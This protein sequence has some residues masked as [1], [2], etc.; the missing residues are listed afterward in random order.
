[1]RLLGQARAGF[2]PCPPEVVKLCLAHHLDPPSGPTALLDPC[3]GKGEA[4]AQLAEGLGATAYG[5]ELCAGRSAEAVNLLPHL[6]GPADFLATDV[7]AGS[8]GLAWVNPPY[9]DEIGGGRRVE[10]SFLMRVT[11]LLVKHG[12]LCFLTAEHVLDRWELREYLP[13]QYEDLSAWAFPSEH[14]RFREVVVFGRRRAQAVKEVEPLGGLKRAVL[15]TGAPARLRLP[16]SPGPKTFAK[17]GFTEEELGEALALSPLQKVMTTVRLP[18]PA[19]PPLP[20]AKGHVALMLAAGHLDGVVHPDGEPPHVVR[21]TAT[22][23]KFISEQSEIATENGT[24]TR[25]VVSEKIVL[26]VRTAHRDGT[27]CTYSNGN[28]KEV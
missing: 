8:F 23:E 13:Q 3:C 28:G 9:D 11:R 24:T 19:R 27:I 20:L 6:L 10:Y 16:P 2:F 26:V 17:A 18:E 1:M 15:G 12:V 5:I 7:S 22:K 4:A 14:R 25:T 21:G